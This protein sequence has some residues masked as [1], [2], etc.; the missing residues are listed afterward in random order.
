MNETL[1]AN[2]IDWSSQDVTVPYNTLT[3]G[4]TYSITISDSS[5]WNIYNWDRI[6]KQCPYE[7][8]KKEFRKRNLKKLLEE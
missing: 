3:T 2:D 6:L 7:N 1:N 5:N 4:T 8:L